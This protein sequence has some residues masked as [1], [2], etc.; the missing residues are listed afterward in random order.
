[1]HFHCFFSISIGS[2]FR[3]FPIAPEDNL[4][5]LISVFRPDILAAD[6][7]VISEAMDW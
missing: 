3:D 7:A 5:G 4:P 1:L 6:L 2:P